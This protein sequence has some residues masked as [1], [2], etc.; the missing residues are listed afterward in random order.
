VVSAHARLVGR[1]GKA[2]HTTSLLLNRSTDELS[3]VLEVILIHVD[4]TSRRAVEFPSNMAMRI[5]ETLQ[6]HLTLTW[7]PPLCGSMRLRS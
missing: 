3:Y 6:R 4:L 1:S 5:D 7:P 2:V